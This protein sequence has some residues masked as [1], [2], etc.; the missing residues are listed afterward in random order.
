MKSRYSCQ[1]KRCKAR[2]TELYE[3]LPWLNLVTLSFHGAYSLSLS[4][5]FNPPALDKSDLKFSLPV[6]CRWLH[7]GMPLGMVA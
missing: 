1:L 2:V 4:K 6:Q 5:Q 3:A 7:Q